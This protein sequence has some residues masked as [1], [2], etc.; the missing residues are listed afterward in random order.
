MQGWQTLPERPLAP[1][2]GLSGACAP[3][4]GGEWTLQDLAGFSKGS[5]LSKAQLSGLLLNVLEN[6]HYVLLSLLPF[7]TLCV[8]LF[9]LPALSPTV[10]VHLALRRLCS[11]FSPQ[12][13]CFPLAF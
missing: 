11:T 4:A 10:L 7:F 1:L 9:T 2:V 13:L 8:L 12:Y 5:G 6:Y 3:L